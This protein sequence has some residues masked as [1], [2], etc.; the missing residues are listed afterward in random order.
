MRIMAEGRFLRMVEQDGWEFIE[1]TGI[2]G[3]VSI[4]ATTDDNK[5][6]LVEQN[7]IPVKGRTIEL[8][9]GLAGDIASAENEELFEA[10]RRELLEETGYKA[11][12]ME[13]LA[14]GP[15]SAGCSSEHLT[16]FRALSVAKVSE[17][18]GDGTEEIVVHEVPLNEV[19]SWLRMRQRQGIH[20]SIRIYSALYFLLEEVIAEGT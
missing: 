2:S 3:I 7:R 17:G 18:G 6:I 19:R 5:V 12:L 13:I 16:L 20:V 1:R 14:D 8:P 9:S 4:L 11:G 15:V 10:A